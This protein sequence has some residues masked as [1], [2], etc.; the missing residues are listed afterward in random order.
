M[1]TYEVIDLQKWDKCNRG[2][3]CIHNLLCGNMSKKMY[4]LLH[5]EIICFGTFGSFNKIMKSSQQFFFK[6]PM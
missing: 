1:V 3:F 4:I 5:S 6:V 2:H